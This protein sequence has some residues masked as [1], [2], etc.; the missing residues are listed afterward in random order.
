MARRETAADAT[1]DN[2]YH[3]ERSTFPRSMPAQ[4]FRVDSNS[5]NQYFWAS[6]LA[7]G[8]LDFQLKALDPQAEPI[9]ALGLRES[10]YQYRLGHSV[11]HVKSMSKEH[12][13]WRRLLTLILLSAAL[14]RYI[15]AAAE[16]AVASDPALIA[17]FDKRLDGLYVR[18]RKLRMQKPDLAGLTIG[19]WPSRFKTYRSLF[20][21]LPSEAAEHEGHLE[22]LRVTRNQV[23]HSLGLPDSDDST[24]TDSLLATVLGA[25]RSSAVQQVRISDSSVKNLMRVGG[26]FVEAVDAHLMREFIGGFEAAALFLDWSESPDRFERRAG[27]D[28]KG[29]LKEHSQ[30]FRK[31]YGVLIGSPMHRTYYVTMK[32]YVDSL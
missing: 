30:R 19:P 32:R 11:E 15:K 17:G 3:R 5:V 1:N 2:T 16:L 8:G 27:I 20:G 25:R 10:D 24:P 28:L 31:M 9:A 14:E 6:H 26:E 22:R 23:A 21:T 13:R 29:G 18:K 4:R 12:W 7:A